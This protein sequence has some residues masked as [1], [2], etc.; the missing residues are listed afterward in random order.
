MYVCV[1]VFLY[2]QLQ[3]GEHE[4]FHNHTSTPPPTPTPPH[5]PPHSHVLVDVGSKK[6]ASIQAFLRSKW[7][8]AAYTVHAFE[9]NPEHLPVLERVAR[10]WGL[11]DRITVHPTAAWTEDTSVLLS[12]SCD[13]GA[14]MQGG[15][16][17]MGSRVW[18][19]VAWLWRGG[20]ADVGGS[21]FLPPNDAGRQ[22]KA[23]AVDFSSWLLK[24]Y[25]M[26]G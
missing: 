22:H 3:K 15:R 14:G 8:G 12:T 5:S 11:G 20:G 10:R 23:D 24:T 21:M 25:G 13:V 26:M 4:Q 2:C 7:D 19:M 9:P 1:Y 18:E 17:G 16:G 6:G